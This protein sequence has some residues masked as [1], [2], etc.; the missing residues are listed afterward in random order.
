MCREKG[1]DCPCTYVCMKP[2]W[3]GSWLDTRL[4]R[5]MIRIPKNC[6]AFSF[7]ATQVLSL[8]RHCSY[9]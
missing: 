6:A 2:D 5:H 3:L 4:S 9:T 8:Y 7:P 1:G